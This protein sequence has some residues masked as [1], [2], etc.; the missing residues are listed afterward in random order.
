MKRHRRW[1]KVLL[2]P[3]VIIGAIVMTAILSL[4]KPEQER[5][6]PVPIHPK[7]EVHRVEAGDGSVTVTSEG[8]VRARRTTRLTAR[9]SGQIE[10][11]SPS[12]YEGGMF[13][14]GESLL[15]LDPLPYKSALAEAESRLALA[16]ATFLQEQEAAAQ[17]RLD[18][19]AIGS[20]EPGP[21]VLRE[22]QM[23][24]A[25]AD[26]EAAR[27]AVEMARQNLDY[28]T[29]TAPYDG[30]VDAKFVDVGQAITA[31]ATLLGEIHATDSL[32]IPIPLS[33]D[34]LARIAVPTE[35]GN[36]KPSAR[37]T[38]EIAGKVHE[39]Q[40]YIDRTAASVNPQSRMIT[41]IARMD[42]P[43]SSKAGAVLKPGMF[44]TVRIE[45]KQ[46]GDT[47]RIPRSAVHPG[48]LVYRVTGGD[49]LESVR[50]EV[51]HTDSGEAVISEGLSPGDR[52]CLTP[53]LFFVE[54]MRVEV[55]DGSESGNA[56]S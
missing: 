46:L 52:L 17:A 41:V 50:V 4:L 26:R 13:S 36:G 54:G 56:P 14:A 21:L 35:S 2:P 44:V 34:E 45:G 5:K 10:W 55:V 48:D 12:F 51:I 8:S 49:R 11:V 6:E 32:E 38:A 20:G 28:T 40:G 27:V 22:P 9:V 47:V 7:V 16:E 3:M 18:W 31:Q 42:A 43:F 53:L 33:L 15:R 37:F 19:E 30:R 29:I 39:W 1:L 23:M 24:K 25:R